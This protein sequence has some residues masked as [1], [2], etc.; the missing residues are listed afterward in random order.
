MDIWWTGSGYKGRYRGHKTGCPSLYGI[1]P[2]EEVRGTGTVVLMQELEL[3]ARADEPDV[4]AK[5]VR[6]CV[7]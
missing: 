6:Q 2:S 4:V 1:L 5:G 3:G 7:C